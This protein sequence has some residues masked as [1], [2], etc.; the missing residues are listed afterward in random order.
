LA[1]KV[2]GFREGK[3]RKV[4]ISG[5]GKNAAAYSRRPLNRSKEGKMP[6]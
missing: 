2:G 3:E 6:G 5:N 1:N 4:K